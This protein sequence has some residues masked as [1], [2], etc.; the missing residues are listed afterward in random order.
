VRRGFAELSLAVVL[1]AA[2]SSCA[3]E[4]D[5]VPDESRNVYGSVSDGQSGKRLKGVTIAFTSDTLDR[6]SD[7]TDSDGKY[8]LTV[9]TDS[10]KGRIEAKK[11]GY[12]TRMVSVFFD[13]NSV[14]ID[15]ELTP[16]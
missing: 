11:S 8:S 15:V 2:I 12:E 4:D 1:C 7:T 13:T 14:Q 6:A 9:A 5:R 10:K 3:E 16:N